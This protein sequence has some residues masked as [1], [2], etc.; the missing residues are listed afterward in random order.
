MKNLVKPFNFFLAIFFVFYT[1]YI[2]ADLY[3]FQ[4]IKPLP[5]AVKT[6]DNNIEIGYAFTYTAQGGS[7]AYQGTNNLT[8][9]FL[10]DPINTTCKFDGVWHSLNPQESCNIYLYFAPATLP[11][12]PYTSPVNF[13]ITGSTGAVYTPQPIYVTIEN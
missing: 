10:L 4:L 3:S 8:S 9:P 1:T 13:S 5:P 6:T 12:G 11:L 7:G 2:F